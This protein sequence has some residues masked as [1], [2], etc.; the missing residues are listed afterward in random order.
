MQL[1]IPGLAYAVVAVDGIRESGVLGHARDGATFSQDTALR[2]ASVS[3]SLAGT[4]LA[5]AATESRLD[6]DQPAH[7]LIPALESRPQITIRHLAAHVSEGEPGT[8]YVYGTQRFAQLE[9]ALV[10]AFEAATYEQLLQQ[11]IIEPAGMRWH[12]SPDLGA[13]AGLVS[14]VNDMAL[15]VGWLLS[16]GLSEDVMDELL[17]PYRLTSG[18]PGP[19]SLGWFVQK[20]GDETVL[21]SF[22]QDD[23]DHS[24]ALVIVV[25]ERSTG[26]VLLANS[27]AASNPFRLL[28]GD[29]RYS[30]FAAAFLDAYAPNAGRAISPAQRGA[31]GVLSAAF[32][33]DL[34]N[35]EQRFRAWWPDCDE[36]LDDSDLVQHFMVT[37]V[38]AALA[39]DDFEAFDRRVVA[40]YPSN[41]WPLLASAS[42]AAALNRNAVSSQR[43][44]AII[45]LPDQNQDFLRRLFQ[46]WAYR[47]LATNASKLDPQRALDFIELGLDTGIGGPTRKDLEALRAAIVDER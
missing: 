15:W 12:P 46:A 5:L 3:K 10:K 11:R 28:M 20:L 43:Y 7:R 14:T 6:L 36:C 31:S 19:V 42:Y 18:E 32:V 37:S 21:W 40:A 30:P 22:G 23:P 17:Q 38:G 45:D 41:R 29:V 1:G 25:P 9:T 16:K 47:G 8:T 35:A 13:H 39:M 4:L 26:L 2:F 33:G 27:D 24:S 44:Q 34:D